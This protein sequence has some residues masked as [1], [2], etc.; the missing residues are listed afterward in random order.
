RIM[1]VANSKPEQIAGTW[2][3]LFEYQ[4]DYGQFPGFAPI[5]YQSP[6]CFGTIHWATT[7]W[8]YRHRKCT[9]SRPL[10][11]HSLRVW[12]MRPRSSSL[13]T[14]WKVC[15]KAPVIS[16]PATLDNTTHISP[17]TNG[18]LLDALLQHGYT[19][20]A[21]FLFDNLW[22]AMISA[23]WEIVDS[24]LNVTITAPVGTDG[25]FEVDQPSSST[26]VYELHLE[27]TEAATSFVV[28][29]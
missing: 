6:S 24:Q 29:L 25:T 14:A 18:F 10:R 12:P 9:A 26:G 1:G 19:D 21:V 3:F 17:N 8:T 7:L 20:Q 28:Q 15:V 4:A 11:L 13:L 27:G 5:S 16:I 2:E 22:D 23:A